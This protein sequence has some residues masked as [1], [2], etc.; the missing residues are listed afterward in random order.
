MRPIAILD[1]YLKLTSSNDPTNVLNSDSIVEN[2]IGKYAWHSNRAFDF[3]EH[4]T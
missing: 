4:E 1:E 3:V 2:Q